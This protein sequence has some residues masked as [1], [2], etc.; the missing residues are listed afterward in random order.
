[1]GDTWATDEMR[2]IG[3]HDMVNAE[4]QFEYIPPASVVLLGFVDEIKTIMRE[5]YGKN[6][7][8]ALISKI[9]EVFVQNNIVWIFLNAQY[10]QNAISII[11]ELNETEKSTLFEDILREPIR[12]V[13]AKKYKKLFLGTKKRK[14]SS[15]S[16]TRS[17]GGK[18]KNRKS[19]SRK[20]R[21]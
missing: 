18:R 5:F 13:K 10:P 16:K 11:E 8:T 12:G 14:R 2:H 1:M 6:P 3:R 21:R 17:Q 4:G 20:M 19:R 9:N 15:I 7:Q